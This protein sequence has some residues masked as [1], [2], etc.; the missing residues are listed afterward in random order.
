[1]K[2]NS[3]SRAMYSAIF[4][5]ACAND[6][7]IEEYPNCYCLDSKVYYDDEGNELTG[8]SSSLLFNS[9]YTG[10]VHMVDADYNVI[11][12]RDFT[13]SIVDGKVVIK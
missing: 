7:Y 13:W 10:Y 2:T 1:M 8:N 5:Y 3:F 12:N 9:D 4:S 11:E 6:M